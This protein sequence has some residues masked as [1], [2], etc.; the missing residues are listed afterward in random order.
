MAIISGSN[1]DDP[2]NGTPAGTRKSTSA[3]FPK[4]LLHMCV[5]KRGTTKTWGHWGCANLSSHKISIATS[6]AAGGSIQSLAAFVFFSSNMFS[7]VTS[8]SGSPPQVPLHSGLEAW[9][10]VRHQLLTHFPTRPCDR[11]SAPRWNGRN[12]IGSSPAIMPSVWSPLDSPS[13]PV[14]FIRLPEMCSKCRIKPPSRCALYSRNTML[15]NSL[16]V[17]CPL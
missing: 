9:S 15:L 16:L 17:E 11:T 4:F 13:T 8:T 3:D 1:C 10:L 12:V 7:G 5:I 6:M 2:Q 14:A